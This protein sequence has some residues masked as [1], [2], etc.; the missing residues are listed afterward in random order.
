MHTHTY[1]STYTDVYIHL[2]VH[3]HMHSHK[4]I[5]IC[6]HNTHTYTYIDRCVREYKEGKNQGNVKV[7]ERVSKRGGGKD[8]SH[9]TMH[10][11]PKENV[12]GK[13]LLLQKLQSLSS[14]RFMLR[15]EVCVLSFR[16]NFFFIFS[17][18]VLCNK[19]HAMRM[20]L[21]LSIVWLGKLQWISTDAVWICL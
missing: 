17:S 2:H 12:Y 19:L 5:H 11:S 8:L 16:I 15:P 18:L 9:L 1:I 4:Y 3:I 10:F 21:M 6:I 14:P 20:Y 7:L 13:S